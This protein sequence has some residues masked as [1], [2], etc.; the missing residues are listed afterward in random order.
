MDIDEKSLTA[1]VRQIE[2]TWGTEGPASAALLHPSRCATP[3]VGTIIASNGWG[4]LDLLHRCERDRGRG[5]SHRRHDGR[6]PDVISLEITF[7]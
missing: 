3:P 6:R 1:K 2:A 5:I 4:G 7:H